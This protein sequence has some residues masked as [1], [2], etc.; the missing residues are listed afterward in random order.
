[1]FRPSWM[2]REP[3]ATHNIS[4]KSLSI[5]PHP[6]LCRFCL[7]HSFLARAVLEH[8]ATIAHLFNTQPQNICRCQGR[9]Q[10]LG[11]EVNQVLG[12]VELVFQ[13]WQ[14]TETGQCQVHK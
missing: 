1:M 2:P 7:G 12:R 14:D 6:F 11:G 10:T 8:P 13:A 4:L 5:S 3:L 9:C